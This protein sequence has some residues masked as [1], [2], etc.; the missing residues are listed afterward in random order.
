VAA[1]LEDREEQLISSFLL[2]VEASRVAGRIGGAAP[3]V[4]DQALG[5]IRRVQISS[6]IIANAAL[7]LPG[8]SLGALDAIHLAT[9]LSIPD[10]TT[11]VTY[12]V[13][14]REACQQVGLAVLA[15]A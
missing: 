14:L 9:A 3:A 6:T 7:I 15:P 10:D 11:V 2:D 12:D 4:V 5:R 1:L 8:S 13:R